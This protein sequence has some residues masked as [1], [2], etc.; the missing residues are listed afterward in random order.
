MQ[1]ISFQRVQESVENQVI[2]THFIATQ[3]IQMLWVHSQILADIRWRRCSLWQTL[4]HTIQKGNYRF[5]WQKICQLRI[6]PF[7][8]KLAVLKLRI[9]MPI[10]KVESTRWLPKANILL[11]LT[12]TVVQIRGRRPWATTNGLRHGR[13]S[14]SKRYWCIISR[15][16]SEEDSEDFRGVQKFG[17]N[18]RTEE[19]KRN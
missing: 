7:S 4:I 16:R 1:L 19:A 5:F 14:S 6:L 10:R 8:S 17:G 9:T 3:N 12:W 13:R 18:K 2:R 15:G 11:A